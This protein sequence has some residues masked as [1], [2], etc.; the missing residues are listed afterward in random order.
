MTLPKIKI[1]TANAA[2]PPPLA[3]KPPLIS[4]EKNQILLAAPIF[5]TSLITKVKTEKGKVFFYFLLFVFILQIIE[6]LIFKILVKI[7]KK[8]DFYLIYE[9]IKK[10]GATYS[11]LYSL[12][13]NIDERETNPVALVM[14]SP[15][16]ENSKKYFLDLFS[17]LE[18]KSFQKGGEK[19]KIPFRNSHFKELL[20]LLSREKQK[21]SS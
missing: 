7:R 3:T 1:H 11:R 14:K 17:F 10:K 20:G 21:R 13:E 6:F 16:K 9:E 15:L 18:E 4:P 12:F 5:E 8:E 2:P 19:T